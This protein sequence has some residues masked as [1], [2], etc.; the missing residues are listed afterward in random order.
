MVLYMHEVNNYTTKHVTTC[1][2]V[3]LGYS[4]FLKMLREEADLMHYNYIYRQ[5]LKTED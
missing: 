2:D 1:L 3:R 4:G 5:K